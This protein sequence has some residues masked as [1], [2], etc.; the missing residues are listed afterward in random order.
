MYLYKTIY[1]EFKL[2]NNLINCP[3]LLKRINFKI[4]FIGPRDKSLFYFKNTTRNYLWNSQCKCLK[5]SSH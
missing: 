2:L 1:N 5:R 3:E 4:N